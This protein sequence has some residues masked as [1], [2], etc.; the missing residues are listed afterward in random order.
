[1]APSAIKSPR[2]TLKA[3]N[4]LPD[5]ELQIPFGHGETYNPHMVPLPNLSIISARTQMDAKN[6]ALLIAAAFL[7]DVNMS[8]IKVS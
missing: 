2:S 5:W 4:Y 6:K 3:Q 8:C 7:S 1:M